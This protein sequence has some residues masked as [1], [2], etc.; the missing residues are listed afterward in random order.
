V[1]AILDLT[2]DD[3][4]IPCTCS[5]TSSGAASTITQHT[6]TGSAPMVNVAGFGVAGAI[7]AAFAALFL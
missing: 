7:G 5:S 4:N 1:S 2:A 6:F 3:D